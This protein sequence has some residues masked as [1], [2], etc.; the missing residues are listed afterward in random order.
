MQISAIG[1]RLV[2]AG[3]KLVPGRVERAIFPTKD[4]PCT[5]T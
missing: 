1:M 4:Q 3:R 2:A 5:S